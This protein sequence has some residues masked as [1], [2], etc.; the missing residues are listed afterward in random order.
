VKT[1]YDSIKGDWCSKK[2]VVPFGVRVEIYKL[3]VGSFVR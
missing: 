3:G 2:V 1:K